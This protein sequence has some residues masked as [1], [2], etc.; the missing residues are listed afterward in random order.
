M[1]VLGFQGLWGLRVLGASVLVAEGLWGGDLALSC[2]VFT[3]SGVLCL[4][5][6]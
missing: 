2:V 4:W 3:G 5:S 6:L 1:T